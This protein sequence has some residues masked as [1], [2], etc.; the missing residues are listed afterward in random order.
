[1]TRSFVTR[2]LEEDVHVKRGRGPA[3]NMR[4]GPSVILPRFSAAA[5]GPGW[6]EPNKEILV[7]S[8]KIG[9]AIRGW[10]TREQPCLAMS[11]PI[12]LTYDLENLEGAP[13]D[14]PPL[15]TYRFEDRWI[16]TWLFPR[17]LVAGGYL[18]QALCDPVILAVEGHV[19]RGNLVAAMYAIWFLRDVPEWIDLGPVARLARAWRH[20]GDPRGEIAE[21]LQSRLQGTPEEQIEK[22]LEGIS[23]AV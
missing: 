9:I 21:L 12:R 22:L 19:Q 4:P 6:S 14:F 8:A 2:Q 11:R 18:D 13:P 23:D 17:H 7:P 1:L 16:A 5:S 20:P 15:I 3:R 10:G